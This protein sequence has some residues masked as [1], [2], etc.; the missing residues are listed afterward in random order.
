M[1]ALNTIRNLTPYGAFGVAVLALAVLALPKHKVEQIL[2]NTSIQVEDIVAIVCNGDGFS[3]FADDPEKTKMLRDAEAAVRRELETAGVDLT[4]TLPIDPGNVIVCDT[5]GGYYPSGTNG[6]MIPNWVGQEWGDFSY[7]GIRYSSPAWFAVDME[8]FEEGKDPKGTVA[9]EVAHTH[10]KNKERP[11]WLTEHAAEVVSDDDPSN[12]SY[13]I[14]YVIWLA[15]SKKIE[16]AGISE[17]GEAFLLK[18]A[19]NQDGEE[20]IDDDLLDQV[21]SDLEAPKAEKEKFKNIILYSSADELEIELERFL[22][23]SEWPVRWVKFLIE[24]AP[25]EE[26]DG[27]I[28]DQEIE[29][30]VRTLNSTFIERE[31][32]KTALSARSLPIKNNVGTETIS[33]RNLDQYKRL[34]RILS[35]L[36]GDDTQIMGKE[37]ENTSLEEKAELYKQLRGVLVRNHIIAE[38]LVKPISA[39]ISGVIGGVFLWRRRKKKAA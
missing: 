39:A 3:T 1:G 16:E 35:L 22:K 24:V 15:L 20:K 21:L 33:I 8:L 17:D 26:G 38:Y 10:Q 11:E 27:S 23:E 36:G 18:V 28:W 25:E 9:H 2:N 19:N 29:I 34:N 13:P 4:G 30:T 7:A 6:I 12:G 37:L 32:E 31:G 5:E 14:Q